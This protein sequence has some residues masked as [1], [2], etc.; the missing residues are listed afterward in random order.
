MLLY[1]GPPADLD[2]P[3]TWWHAGQTLYRPWYA[4]VWAEAA[5]LDK[6]G[7]A[8][9][10][11]EQARYAARHNPITSAMIERAAAFSVGN[12]DAVRDLAVT[13]EALGCPYQQERTRVIATMMR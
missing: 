10:R 3:F 5:V 2:D 4:A 7:D 6:R 11:V 1:A 8:P 12:R 13:F 9:N